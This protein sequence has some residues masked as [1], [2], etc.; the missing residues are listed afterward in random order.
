MGMGSKNTLRYV[1]ANQIYFSTGE[2]ISSAL[3]AFHKLFG[4]NYTPALSRKGKVRLLK[5]LERS[6]KARCA[7]SNLPQDIVRI[8]EEVTDIEKFICALD[9]KKKLCEKY[10]DKM[11]INLS[12]VKFKSFNGSCMPSCKTFW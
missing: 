11:I 5:I 4:C 10:K 12:I 1:S 7:F 9:G 2:L 3:P 8:D 6:H